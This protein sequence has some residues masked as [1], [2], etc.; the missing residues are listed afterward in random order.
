MLNESYNCT[1]VVWRRACDRKAQPHGKAKTGSYEHVT[2]GPAS[3]SPCLRMVFGSM[4]C[5]GTT[6]PEKK[7][8]RNVSDHPR[9]AEKVKFEPAAWICIRDT[10]KKSWLLSFDLKESKQCTEISRSQIYTQ[11][12]QLEW[13]LFTSAQLTTFFPL[14]RST[15]LQLSSVL[16]LRCQ[17]SQMTHENQNEERGPS[18]LDPYALG[19]FV[20]RKC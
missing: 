6:L 7:D 3:F 14:C 15:A 13:K 2:R 17:K 12:E 16:V 10:A 19:F 20:R 11:T 5:D 18:S 9:W 4:F 8:R 1:R